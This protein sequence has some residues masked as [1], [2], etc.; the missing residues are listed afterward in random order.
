MDEI[1]WRLVDDTEVEVHGAK[2]SL[3]RNCN[4]RPAEFVQWASDTM[5]VYLCT[6]C[7]TAVV[8]GR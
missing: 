5:M 2:G 6:F 3:C 1:S 7:E 8:A 4:L